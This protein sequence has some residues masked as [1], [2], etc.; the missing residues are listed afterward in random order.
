VTVN[1]TT[2]TPYARIL[3]L[4]KRGHIKE[5]LRLS[6]KATRDDASNGKLWE[7]RGCLHRHCGEWASGRY[8]L[9]TATVLVP[10][11]PAGQCCLADC[12]RVLDSEELAAEM[13][14]RLLWNRHATSELLLQVANGFDELNE[15]VQAV[16]ACRMALRRDADNAQA[17]YDMGFYMT[18]AGYPFSTVEATARRAVSLAP[19]R[20][21]FRTG[22]V[23]LLY[24]AGKPSAAYEEA[25]R[26]R[27]GQ[28]HRMTCRCCL[29][30]LIEVFESHGDH[31][32]S[33]CVRERLLSLS[34]T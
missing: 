34:R 17:Y 6:K 18:R 12:Y 7:I 20:V 13:Y 21:D 19:E 27:A 23:G 5:A 32:R 29:Q 16:T 11:S 10:L 9:E 28:I 3:D 31:L 25:C 15:P 4:F 2:T 14:R 24:V 1:S 30:R 8:A 33:E 26:L 22:L